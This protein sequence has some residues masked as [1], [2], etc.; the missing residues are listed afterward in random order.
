VSIRQW[1][2]SAKVFTYA[3]FLMYSVS[4]PQA[5]ENTSFSESL[6]NIEVVS[7]IDDQSGYV[8]L[9]D[10][11]NDT[12]RQPYNG[13][14][15]TNAEES[16]IQF[17]IEFGSWFGLQ[18]STIELNQMPFASDD[19]SNTDETQVV[20]SFNP[21]EQSA[22]GSGPKAH[23]SILR[24][25]QKKDGLRV[26]GSGL[27]V[28]QDEFAEVKGASVQISTASKPSAE[29]KIVESQ[30]AD[31]AKR[32]TSAGHPELTANSLLVS[33][34]ELVVFNPG[35]IGAG[36]NV[37]YLVWHVQVSD[38]S[39]LYSQVFIDATTG[40]VLLFLEPTDE[41]YGDT[42]NV[43]DENSSASLLLLEPANGEELN[44]TSVYPEFKWTAENTDSNFI[45]YVAQSGV[46]EGI[47][48][49]TELP[50]LGSSCSDDNFGVCSATVPGTMP[51]GAIFNW[52]VGMV[53]DNVSSASI[54]WSKMRS[55]RYSQLP[56]SPIDLQAADLL[57]PFEN[58]ST[59]EAQTI[60]LW[61]NRGNSEWFRLLVRA[62]NSG[63]IA[64][65]GLWIDAADAGCSLA[66][67][68]A[69]NICVGSYSG[70]LSFG[71]EQYC[72]TI[73]PWNVNGIGNP[74]PE[75]CFGAAL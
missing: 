48:L 41:D 50:A 54:A 72:W 18:D 27:I 60:F 45:L 57:Y 51:E 5:S 31:Q 53:D 73:T 75:R 6:G 3:F 37:D 68:S 55:F 44:G 39:L 70:H 30:A 21:L 17:F 35:I 63:L 62:G 40:N 34:I 19:Q 24:F 69:S 32:L 1:Q 61:R 7:K 49:V 66:I 67:D 42:S 10:V 59:S 38:G 15:T 9:F 16:A 28:R 29:I 23:T 47:T 25:V 4:C 33:Q 8:R 43:D 20:G 13:V 52:W 58:E 22:Q 74:S 26:Y 56:S 46:E 64:G 2:F 71:S 11:V 12:V 65:R 14:V 36:P